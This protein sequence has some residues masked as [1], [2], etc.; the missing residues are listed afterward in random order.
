M[1]KTDQQ[2]RMTV[3]Q[4]TRVL[5]PDTR[6]S[7]NDIDKALRRFQVHDE[8]ELAKLDAEAYYELVRSI[9]LPH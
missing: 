2:L 4:H 3:F 5:W 1:W 8:N 7:A 6:F 9:H